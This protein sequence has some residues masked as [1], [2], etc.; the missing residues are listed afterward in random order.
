MTLPNFRPAATAFRPRLLA[1]LVLGSALLGACVPVPHDQPAL[2]PAEA[3]DMGLTGAALAVPIAPDWWQGLGDPQL[4]RIMAEALAG[5][6]GLAQ[7][8][9]RMALA[10]SAIAYTKAGLLPQVTAQASATEERFSNRSI[11]PAPLGGSWNSL[12][13]L[14]ADLSWSLDLAGRQKALV[15]IAKDYAVGSALDVAAARVSLAGAVAQAYVDMA[16]AE[17]LTALSRDVVTAR[18]KQLDLTQARVKAQLA[19]DL[20][21]AAAQTLLAEA[22]QS[23]VRAE[24]Q[25]IIAVHAL[26]ALAGRGTDYAATIQPAALRFDTALP[27]PD[28]LPMDLLARRADIA[29]ARIRV[30]MALGGVKAA[31]AG[32]YPDVSIKAFAGSGSLGLSHLLSAGALT[33]GV[34]PAVHLPIFEG[35][36]LKAGY[37]ASVTGVDIATAQYNEAVAKAVRE[38]ADALSTLDTNRADA[39]AQG[40]VVAG[41]TQ[42]QRLDQIRLQ[43]GLSTRFDT[44]SSAQRLLTARQAQTDLAADGLLARVKLIVA[45]GGGFAP[46]NP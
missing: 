10:Q 14:E 32:F 16:R 2:K 17:A 15:G 44:L 19:S 3:R 25:R 35:G 23:Q 39:Q 30:E 1:T 34:G 43:S 4:N 9:A 8:M 40:Q 18:Q 20:D 12:N 31:R 28:D 42:T 7:T 5:N 36:A 37:R 41:L 22:R 27:V 33:A 38:A 21:I 46:I 6:P 26:A 45:L 11:Y 24:G 13:A 29:S